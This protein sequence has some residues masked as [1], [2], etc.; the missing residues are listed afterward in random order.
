MTPARRATDPAASAR[1]RLE[2][3]ARERKVELQLLLSEFAVERLLYRLGVSRH[4]ERYV[5]KGAMLFKQRGG[6]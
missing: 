3:L 5:L 2:R 6:C 4:D 1:A